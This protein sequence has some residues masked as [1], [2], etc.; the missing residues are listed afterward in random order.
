M[1][2]GLWIALGVLL[3]AAGCLGLGSDEAIEDEHAD[4]EEDWYERAF[5]YEEDHDHTNVSQH[6]GLST[7]NFDVIGYNPLIT[8][9]HGATSG[10]YFCGGVGSDGDREYAVVNSFF[11]D[12]AIVVIDVTD[13]ED[14]QLVGELVLPGTHVYDADITGDARW[15]VLGMYPL[16]EEDEHD[17]ATPTDEEVT[18]TPVWR[19]A[20]GNEHTGHE[21]LVPQ[22][23]GT[24]LVDLGD[25]TNPEV[26]DYDA[27]PPT[28]PHSVF[29]TTIDGE[30]FLLS[31]VP[32]T[33]QATSYYTL[34]N[35]L[36]APISG[37]TLVKAGTWSAQYTDVQT[38]R[39][40][41]RTPLS[42]GHLDGWV[43]KHPITDEIMVYIA[44]WD[45]GII[46]LNYEGPGV[47]T[48][49]GV[50]NDYDEAK[51]PGMSGT[52]HGI[53]PLDETWDGRHYTIIHQEV[54]QSP[55]E[56]PTG[57]VAILD[58][59]DPEDPFPVA[60]WTLPV[61]PPEDAWD[62]HLQFSTHYVAYHDETLFV[63]LYHG[64]VWAVDASQEHWPEMP[65]K[66][67]FIPDQ[68]SPEPVPEALNNYQRWSPIILDVLPLAD[69]SLVT[70]DI[71]GAYTLSFDKTLEI[72]TPDPWHEEPWD[73][74][75][76]EHRNGPP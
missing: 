59:T 76:E 13:P 4:V 72:P 17:Q 67:V 33:Q 8:E 32:N 21:A 70:F 19:D 42:T 48:E 54:G 22:A 30:H 36:D 26:A 75:P 40:E 64:G 65:S 50:W 49:A 46:L 52:W 10:D 14:P 74:I 55:A 3:L 31:S 20:C 18:I 45:G 9:Y 29:A 5:P 23:R 38:D 66:G 25:P 69:G 1:R 27:Q 47:L 68:A 12:V 24:V 44:N 51:G 63:S 2:S 41:E 16:D 61:Q 73:E 34:Y 28:G 6:A 71:T 53:L 43:A 35:V 39:P 57:M 11:T 56:R 7:P 37:G 15:A 60:R 62:A 58:T